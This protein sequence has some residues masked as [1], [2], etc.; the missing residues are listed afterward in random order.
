MVIM[1]NSVFCLFSYSFS[2]YLLNLHYVPSTTLDIGATSMKKT[3]IVLTFME[4]TF[5]WKQI[6]RKYVMW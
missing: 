2:K 6:N 5:Q 1:V 4:H 3:D